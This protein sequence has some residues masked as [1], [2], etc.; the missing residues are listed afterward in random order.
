MDDSVQPAA[1]LPP[2]AQSDLQAIRADLVR[3]LDRPN[4]GRLLHILAIGP[5]IHVATGPNGDRIAPCRDD[6]SPSAVDHKLASFV[7]FG[8]CLQTLVSPIRRPMHGLQDFYRANL[9]MTGDVHDDW[10]DVLERLDNCVG[11][12][13]WMLRLYRAAWCRSGPSRIEA[14]RFS[15][16]KA[17]ALLRI[18]S[19]EQRSP[20]CFDD[21]V[22]RED[23][24]GK[25]F[26][27]LM[28]DVRRE[29]VKLLEEIIDDFEKPEWVGTPERHPTSLSAN[30][31]PE[32]NCD[33][34]RPRFLDGGTLLIGDESIALSYC[35]AKLI[36]TMIDH[37]GMM[38]TPDLEKAGINSPSKL[39]RRIRDKHP[40]LEPF[41]ISPVKKG[42]Q[43]YRV[44]VTD[45]RKS[46]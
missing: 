10:L 14:W 35:A 15:G 18:D 33:D 36:A 1:A 11:P 25:R 6:V 20:S 5:R 40:C 45:C 31:P 12:P 23:E 28:E 29:S 38:L 46:K 24:V 3:R 22:D 34:G 42:G 17:S 27:V 19:D 2:R 41:L 9:G 30:V 13:G 16:G 43:G 21:A 7:D 32:A 39:F 44:R 8:P 4:A 26:L 37:G